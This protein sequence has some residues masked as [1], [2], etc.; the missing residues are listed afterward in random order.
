MNEYRLSIKRITALVLAWVMLLTCM[1]VT[2]LADGTA[3]DSIT[4]TGGEDAQIIPIDSKPVITMRLADQYYVYQQYTGRAGTEIQSWTSYPS[5]TTTQGDGKI[6]HTVENLP[7]G[8]YV[9]ISGYSAPYSSEPG[10]YYG[11]SDNITYTV[12]D[13]SW[14]DI[15]TQ[16]DLQIVGGALVIRKGLTFNATLNAP[17]SYHWGEFGTNLTLYMVKADDSTQTYTFH[18]GNSAPSNGTLTSDEVLALPIGTYDVYLANAT[19]S[20]SEYNITASLNG[21][22]AQSI[23][24]DAAVK[25]GTIDYQYDGATIDVVLKA[26]YK[27]AS[28]VTVQFMDKTA[29]Y[30]NGST[31]YGHGYNYGNAYTAKVDEAGTEYTITGLPAGYNVVISGFAPAT[32]S[33]KGL[34]DNGDASKA[35]YVVYDANGADVTYLY[36]VTVVPGKLTVR[37][38]VTLTTNFTS[39]P[40]AYYGYFD[41]SK[42]QE[43]FQ[44]VLK[45]PGQDSIAA[46]LH[47]GNTAPNAQEQNNAAMGLPVGEYEV[48][49][50]NATTDR[51]NLQAGISNGQ[52][53][54]V[55][56]DTGALIG[57]IDLGYEDVQIVVDL[58]YTKKVGTIYIHKILDETNEDFTDDMYFGFHGRRNTGS[59]GS[60]GNGLSKNIGVQ[61]GTGVLVTTDSIPDAYYLVG[62]YY[63]FY[64]EG[65]YRGGN[66][67]AEGNHTDGTKEADGLT[68]Y[69]APYA[70]VAD[71]NGTIIPSIYDVSTMLLVFQ[72]QEGE[73]HVY[74]H[75]SRIGTDALPDSNLTVTKDW[76]DSDILPES[77]TVRVYTTLNNQPVLLREEEITEEMG[78]KFTFEN[79][80][81]YTA[82]GTA[83]DKNFYIT[84]VGEKEGEEVSSTGV[85]TYGSLLYDATVGTVD[86]EAGTATITNKLRPYALFYKDW[87]KAELAEAGLPTTETLAGNLVLI[88]EKDGVYS[89]RTDRT[90]VITRNGNTDTILF[91]DLAEGANYYLAETGPLGDFEQNTDSTSEMQ[92]GGIVYHAV[93]NGGTL[94]NEVPTANLTINKKVVGDI[95]GSFTVN[96]NVPDN[97]QAAVEKLTMPSGVSYENGK[98][99]ATIAADTPVTIT[100][101]PMGTYTNFAEVIPSE[102]DYK[103]TYEGSAYANGSLTLVEGDNDV[104]VTNRAEKVDVTVNVEWLDTAGVAFVIN[105]QGI[106]PGSVDVTLYG[107]ANETTVELGKATIE[108]EMIKVEGVYQWSGWTH[109]FNDIATGDTDGNPYTFSVVQENMTNSVYTH[110]NFNQI[111]YD[112]AMSQEN[113]TLVITNKLKSKLVDVRVWINED[114]FMNVEADRPVVWHNEKEFWVTMKETS[115]T[116]I[117]DDAKKELVDSKYN[118]VYGISVED[119]EVK[120]KEGNIK[121][122]DWTWTEH[123]SLN[124]YANWADGTKHS[125]IM[126]SGAYYRFVQ[127]YTGVA[128]EATSGK[129]TPYINVPDHMDMGVIAYT[130]TY[131]YTDDPVA[132]P[133]TANDTVVVKT[134]VYL[135]D[136]TF[137]M[138]E[139]SSSIGNVYPGY[140]IKE[141]IIST[142]AEG[143]TVLSE[144]P[145]KVTQQLF[146]T[147]VF[148]RDTASMTVQKT[149]SHSPSQLS[150]SKDFVI[151]VT[152]AAAILEDFKAWMKNNDISN[153]TE[154]EDGTLDVKLTVPNA[155][156]TASRELPKLPTGTYTISEIGGDAYDIVYYDANNQVLS[157]NPDG[158]LTVM[159]NRD[160]DVTVTVDN[161]QRGKITVKKSWLPSWIASAAPDATFTLYRA[162]SSTEGYPQ[163]IDEIDANV[164][165]QVES[166]VLVTGST[167]LTFE[168]VKLVDENGENYKFIVVEDVPKGYS[169]NSVVQQVEFNGKTGA[170]CYFTNSRTTGSLT[171]TKTLSDAI[172]NSAT[173]FNMLLTS[174]DVSAAELTA[175]AEQNSYTVNA[176]GALVVPVSVTSDTVSAS[177]T[178]SDLPT[179]TYKI[180]EN[181]PGYTPTYSPANG[182]VTVTQNEQA[183]L[184]ITNTVQTGSIVLTKTVAN[185]DKL[186]ADTND[187]FKF[188]FTST[189]W[190]DVG[191]SSVKYTINSTDK[192]AVFDRGSFTIEGVMH[193]DTVTITGVPVGDYTVTEQGTDGNAYSYTNNLASTY[194]VTKDQETEVDVTN[195]PQLIEL[196]LN[197]VWV[198]GKNQTNT[199]P[200]TAEYAEDLV[201]VYVSDVGNTDAQAQII[202]AGNIDISANADGITYKIA[203]TNMPEVEGCTA[204]IAECVDNVG[205]TYGVYTQDGTV[206]EIDGKYYAYNTQGTLTN[207]LMQSSASI[208][209]FKV[210]EDIGNV[211]HTSD[212]VELKLQYKNSEGVWKD[213]TSV[214]EWNDDSQS[215]LF[216]NLDMYDDDRYLIEYRVLEKCIGGY[217]ASMIV[218]DGDTSVTSES[219]PA[220]DGYAVSNVAHA[221]ENVKITNTR[222]TGSLT[223]TKAAPENYTLNSL[224]QADTFS[225]I[226]AVPDALNG[227]SFKVGE[228]GDVTAADGKL[229]ISDIAF[230]DS[231]TIN[232]LPTDGYTVSEDAGSGNAYTYTIT[233]DGPVTVTTS[234]AEVIIT[235]TPV[236][237]TVTVKKEW[238]DA[239]GEQ[240]TAADFASSLHLFKDVQGSAVE[241][242]GFTPAYTTSTSAGVVTYEYTW[243]QLPTGVYSIGETV[244]AGYEQDTSRTAELTVNGKTYQTVLE[245]GTLVNRRQVVA[246]TVNKVWNGGRSK[247]YTVKLQ[248]LVNGTW[249]DVDSAT[250]TDTA[251]HFEAPVYD[252]DGELI[253]YRLVEEAITGYTGEFTCDNNGTA[254]NITDTTDTTSTDCATT[255]LETLDANNA[256]RN[257]NVTLT[258][259]YHPSLTITK[260]VV[261]KTFMAQEMDFTVTVTPKNAAAAVMAWADATTLPDNVSV[262]ANGVITVTLA[263][264]DGNADSITLE[265]LPIDIYTV[266]EV[267]E[268]DA[269][270]AWETTIAASPGTS[271]DI[272]LDVD[273]TVNFVNTR[274]LMETS[275]G[276]DGYY[277]FYKFWRDDGSHPEGWEEWFKLLYKKESETIYH[278]LSDAEKEKLDYKVTVSDDASQSKYTN[279]LSFSLLPQY[280]L[281]GNKL[282]YMVT[283]TVPDN[284]DYVYHSVTTIYE[285]FTN[286]FTTDIPVTKVWQNADGEAIAAPTAVTVNI[287]GMNGE[288]EEKYTMELTAD[289]LEKTASVPAFTWDGTPMEYTVTEEGVNNGQLTIGNITYKVTIEKENDGSYTIT[290]EKPGETKTVTIKEP[291]SVTQNGQTINMVEVGGEITYTISYNNHTSAVTDVVV[292]DT[293]PVGLTYVSSSVSVS[294]NGQTLTWMLEDVPAYTSGTITV[295]AKVTEDALTSVNPTLSNEASITVGGVTETTNTVE[296]AVYNPAWTVEKTVTN[297]KNAGEYFAP[298]ETVE[299]KITVKN[300]GNVDLTGLSVTDAITVDSKAAQSLTVTSDDNQINPSNFALAVGGTLVFHATYTVQPDDETIVNEAMVTDGTTEVT[301]DVTTE[302][303]TIRSWKV[304]KT[305]VNQKASYK[306]GDVIT[307]QIVVKNTGNVDL[308]GLKLVD[309]IAVNGG[310]ETILPIDGAN[311]TTFD[312]PLGETKTFTVTYEVTATDTK[313]VNTAYVD[314]EKSTVEADA[315][316]IQGVTVT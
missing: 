136:T 63:N 9:K 107:T 194:T 310:A 168:G 16:Y 184:T 142:D 245:G 227:V 77:I 23:D 200:T 19:D 276:N 130:V 240:P 68:R 182:E 274:K 177:V 36:N 187:K 220:V 297:P 117:T 124:T 221:L 293:L 40:N 32:G 239:N 224:M 315:E 135:K 162:A 271:A 178:L 27:N 199:R 180:T 104:T 153:T 209:V 49:L 223:I 131:R 10:I 232:G 94:T 93:A 302:A 139:Y 118:G 279:F 64:E 70:Y 22:A 7:A 134:N 280:D 247:S 148:E 231:I 56:T 305:I 259:T 229:N 170:E 62:E 119:I 179:G 102:A 114:P 73:N 89:I 103:A 176:D 75:N 281:D 13:A 122:H 47:T 97:L 71:E 222:E 273:Q 140:H 192:S 250:D 277:D 213:H 169:P 101:L 21:A 160:D 74:F 175:W 283:E 42:V 188:T 143:E 254:T 256:V 165:S 164:W 2:V 311:E 316:T 113:D 14:N 45:A 120:F 167:S 216:Y 79:L 85:V 255:T 270:E 121:E 308:T 116:L 313:I 43:D 112:V 195:T 55:T 126:A 84:E 275:Y 29:T 198:D 78:W 138:E 128:S 51:M 35:S 91:S 12:Y 125:N 278:E 98:I 72:L 133:V 76:G 252:A 266:A 258:N 145:E 147:A 5:G 210:W 1:P 196:T 197:K 90:P 304:E 86:L 217:S 206:V 218:R 203:V 233:G 202:P 166:K 241:V 228:K 234:G 158:S 225:F 292:T 243:S 226:V 263:A 111:K 44:I 267:F 189:A 65:L 18:T 269:G 230:G 151:K 261:D 88:E 4:P 211:T 50:L 185:Q 264:S 33:G 38:K 127:Q 144:A 287:T 172:V 37:G 286:V 53:Y 106:V 260:T 303:E 82:T 26:T 268:G 237:A 174:T 159:L 155:S 284:V 257:W 307:Y 57:T 60:G 236:I 238:H 193:N 137:A 246:F 191:V 309:K 295:T 249:T 100:G 154:N 157:A 314:G 173:T 17:S 207:T 212:E 61:P 190:E 109:T 299:Y 204:Y 6:T 171:I 41:W 205:G 152:P 215:Y 92:V 39:D 141:Y 300:T 262:D 251:V 83:Y 201:V 87:S 244:P 272:Y 80:P 81:A 183:E 25:L 105:K 248:K 181:A 3:S 301:D 58:V 108:G 96:F 48:Y 214:A 312:L 69:W 30:N 186:A 161:N 291:V 294:Q 290:N 66:V 31:I 282:E 208:E 52:K 242:A 46:I 110:P 115:R 306:L 129:W 149:M 67:D 219:T 235:N 99:T 288:T 20:T 59:D 285:A 150:P 298:G 296:T 95:T 253:K 163:S 132:N 34:Y 24:S 146:V 11:N 289:A 54:D 123:G 265:D 15:T 156:T 28:D 8:Y